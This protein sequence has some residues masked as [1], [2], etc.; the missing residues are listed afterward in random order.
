MG[1]I[2]IASLLDVLPFNEMAYVILAADAFLGLAVGVTG[3]LIALRKY[4]R[5]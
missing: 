2:G 5:V 4:L 1:S 3:S